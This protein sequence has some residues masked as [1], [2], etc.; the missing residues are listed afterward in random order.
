[1]EVS[2][3]MQLKENTKDLEFPFSH[4][5]IGFSLKSLHQHLITDTQAVYERLSSGTI[6]PF[7][8]NSQEVSLDG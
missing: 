3:H 6:P 2:L 8:L 7:T 5:L 1:M 4:S